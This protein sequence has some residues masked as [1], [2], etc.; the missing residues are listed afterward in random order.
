[1]LHHFM[2]IEVTLHLQPLSEHGQS[3]LAIRIQMKPFAE[4]GGVFIAFAKP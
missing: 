3:P 1:M 4:A 2:R